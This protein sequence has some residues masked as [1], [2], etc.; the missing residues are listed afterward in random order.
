GLVTGVDDVLAA[1]VEGLGVAIEGGGDV[2]GGVGLA[3]VASTT[4][5][6]PLGAE[7]GTEVDGIQGLAE[8]VL[9]PLR[10]V[11]GERAVLEYRAREQV[12][13]RHRDLHARLVEGAPEP[14][15]DL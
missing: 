10:I 3:A 15:E 14:L 8:R 5:D 13:R 1:Q 4:H 2:F 12:R 11:G 7:L 6:V 9:A